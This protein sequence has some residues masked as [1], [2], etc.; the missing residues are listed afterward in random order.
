MD[1]SS[2]TQII[3][4]KEGYDRTTFSMETAEGYLNAGVNTED[5]LMM[6]VQSDVTKAASW[7]IS[8]DGG[9]RVFIRQTRL[10]V[11]SVVV[12]VRVIST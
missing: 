2:D 10:R 3:T 4:L 8:C 12:A 9:L 7:T 5:E 6:D 1:L 11:H